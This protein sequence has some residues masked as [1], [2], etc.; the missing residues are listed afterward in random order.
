MGS[1]LILRMMKDFISLVFSADVH[2][3]FSSTFRI[4]PG[5]KVYRL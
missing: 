1:L 3:G 4:V 2:V 5:V